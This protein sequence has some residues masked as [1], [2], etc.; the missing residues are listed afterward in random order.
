[1][2]LNHIFFL[3]IKTIYVYAE[4]ID[5]Q[6]LKINTKILLCEVFLKIITSKGNLSGNDLANDLINVHTSYPI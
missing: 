2:F 1:M 3:I 6:N 5:E 4:I